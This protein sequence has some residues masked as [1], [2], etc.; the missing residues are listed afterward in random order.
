[1]NGLD[2]LLQINIALGSI[3]QSIEAAL[4]ISN[5][6]LLSQKPSHAYLRQAAIA[7]LN[8]VLL[9]GIK[10]G[11]FSGRFTQDLDAERTEH[12]HFPVRHVSEHA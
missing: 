3:L 12:M 4:V 10:F 1:M 2:T 9:T 11:D 5:R 8:L 7:F 6:H